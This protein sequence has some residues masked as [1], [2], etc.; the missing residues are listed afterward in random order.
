MII[1]P[2]TRYFKGARAFATRSL[3]VL[4]AGSRG[5]IEGG[6]EIFTRDTPL[7]NLYME[8]AMNFLKAIGDD[9]NNATAIVRDI[10]ALHAICHVVTRAKIF[11]SSNP[12]PDNKE[13]ISKTL[14]NVKETVEALFKKI[15]GEGFYKPLKEKL[16]CSYQ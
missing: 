11:D 12:C 10:A 4:H 1:P 8:G 16:D 6:I 14:N 3:K 9:K 13:A 15:E 5:K 2:P 7:Y